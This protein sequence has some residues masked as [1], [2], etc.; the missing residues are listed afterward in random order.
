MAQSRDAYWRFHCPECGFGDREFGHL[1]AADEIHCIICIEEDGR[2]VTLHRWLTEE[3][4]QARLRG[5][6]VAA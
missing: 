3:T 6:F 1:L 5:A 2:E 4:D